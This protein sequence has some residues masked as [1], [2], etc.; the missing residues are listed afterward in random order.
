MSRHR[1]W[2]R[3]RLLLTLSLAYSCIAGCTSTAGPNSNNAKAAANSGIRL[4]SAQEI[5][6]VRQSGLVEANNRFSWQLFNTI[7]QA[8]PGRN[9]FVSPLSAAFAL[10]MTLQGADHQTLVQMKQVLGLASMSDQ[11]LLEHLPLLLRK[12]QRPASDISL[13]IANSIWA[14]EAYPLLPNFMTTVKGP[15]QAEVA[16]VDMASAATV[17]LIND[18]SARATHQKIPKLLEKIDDPRTI[19]FLINAIYFKADWTDPFEKS[20]T[21]DKPFFLDDGSQKAVPMMRKFGKY[22]YLGPNDAFPHQAVAL[23]YG[24]EGKLRM[25]AFLPT[26]GQKLADLQRDLL[27]Q[28]FEVLEKRFYEEGGSV[29]LP[30]FK[31][32]WARRLNK[33]LIKLGMNDAFSPAGADFSKM[34][35]LSKVGDNVYLSFVDQLSYVDINEEGTEAA[36]VTIAAPVPASSEPMKTLDIRFDHPFVFMIRDQETGQILFLGSITDPTVSKVEKQK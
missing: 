7:Y 17:K 12:L 6:Q 8:D 2:Y 10:Q 5:Q 36:A 4:L 33:D 24:K 14:N 28:D 20:E 9:Q 27:A 16:N 21:S 11:Q 3:L 19:A 1:K 26:T 23:P 22:L 31:M 34:V 35:D 13:E 32:E 25:Y 29:Q 18:W 30:K 15:F